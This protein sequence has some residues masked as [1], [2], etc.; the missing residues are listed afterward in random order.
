MMCSI[1]DTWMKNFTAIIQ[2]LF[3]WHHENVYKKK[4]MV[5]VVVEMLTARLPR[6]G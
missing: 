1:M 3:S 6:L 5:S 4:I 2:D